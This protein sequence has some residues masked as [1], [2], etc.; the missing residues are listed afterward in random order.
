[1]TN[2]QMAVMLGMHKEAEM[3]VYRPGVRVWV[4]RP[5]DEEAAEAF[6]LAH[7]PGGRADEQPEQKWP[8]ERSGVYGEQIA[9]SDSE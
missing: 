9:T 3:S 2:A 5:E 7:K 8:S 4:A 6:I 1:M